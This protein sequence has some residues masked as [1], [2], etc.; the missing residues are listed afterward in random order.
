VKLERNLQLS[1]HFVLKF[2]TSCSC[3]PKISYLINLEN[4]T[5]DILTDA[6]SKPS[7]N[8]EEP[9][10]KDSTNTVDPSPPKDLLS[11]ATIELVH[12]P[13]PLF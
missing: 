12:Q 11:H 2:I 6:P 10:E 9:K 3:P 5:D 1:L 8:Q 13:V 4:T 7:F